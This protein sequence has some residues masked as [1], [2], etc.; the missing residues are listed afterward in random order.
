MPIAY[1]V[2]D[3]LQT[4]FASVKTLK[5]YGDAKFGLSSANNDKYIRHWTEINF[6]DF[7]YPHKGF[8]LNTNYK[9]Y[10]INNGGDFRRWYGNNEDVIF[11][12]NDGFE[13]KNNG[14]ST[15]RNKSYYYKDGI[16]W[17]PISSSKTAFRRFEGLYIY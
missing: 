7:S 14:K 13:L 10:P 5:Y 11:W 6:S 8:K 9:W 15:I 3:Q 17:T 1:W 2:K 16:T 12:L 4:I